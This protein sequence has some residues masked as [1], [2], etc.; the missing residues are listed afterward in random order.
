MVELVEGYG[1]YAMKRAV[2]DAVDSRNSPTRLVRHLVALFFSN[3]VLCNSNA[4]G[5]GKKQHT[6]LDQDILGACYMQTL[7]IYCYKSCFYF[8]RICYQSVPRYC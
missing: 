1:I 4:Y 8:D 6:A 5:K 7:C 3:D 2:D